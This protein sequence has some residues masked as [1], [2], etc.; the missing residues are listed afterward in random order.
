M[1]EIIYGFK[2]DKCKVEVP[3]KEEFDLKA[4]TNYVTTQIILQ[5]MVLLILMEQSIHNKNSKFIIK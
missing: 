1:S 3:T 5:Q 4:N 2:E